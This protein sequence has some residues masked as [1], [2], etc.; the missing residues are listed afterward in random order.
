MDDKFLKKKE[1]FS[2]WIN[3]SQW[4]LS[5]ERIMSDTYL[6]IVYFGM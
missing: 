5:L 6:P 2:N 3:V 1:K 4:K